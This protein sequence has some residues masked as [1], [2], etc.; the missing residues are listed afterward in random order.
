MASL[1]VFSICIRETVS[2]TADNFMLN[3]WFWTTNYLLNNFTKGYLDS[4]FN[5]C[6]KYKTKK[7]KNIFSIP[8]P[9][10][11]IFSFFLQSFRS[12]SNAKMS[13]F[14]TF[15]NVNLWDNCLVLHFLKKMPFRKFFC[16]CLHP[17]YLF[18]LTFLIVPM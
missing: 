7:T 9:C 6:E 15:M 10:M 4:F 17:I 11:V 12:W 1:Y 14:S 5:I 13:L 2:W 3:M 16:R 18:Q 8:K